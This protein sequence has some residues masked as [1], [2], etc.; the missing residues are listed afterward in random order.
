ME[1]DTFHLKKSIF[2]KHLPYQNEL[3]APHAI[4]GMHLEKNVFENTI[5]LLLDIKGKTKDSLKSRMD[6]INQ[7]IKPELHPGQPNNWEVNIPGARATT[8]LQTMFLPIIISAIG[9][10]YV[11]MVITRMSYFFNHIT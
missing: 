6:L 10:E 4:D 7:G 8:W 3:E 1:A 11:K 5:C 2:F 9:H